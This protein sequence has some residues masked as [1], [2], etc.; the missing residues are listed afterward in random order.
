MAYLNMIK[1]CKKETNS[2][3]HTKVLMSKQSELGSKISVRALLPDAKKL[4]CAH[5]LPG[6]H[7]RRITEQEY[8]VQCN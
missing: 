8:L 5:Q 7:K 4:V 3:F 1:R 6:S 2:H